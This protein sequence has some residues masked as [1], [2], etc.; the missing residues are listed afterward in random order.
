MD[1]ETSIPQRIDATISAHKVNNITTVQEIIF[2]SRSVNIHQS[3]NT[4]KYAT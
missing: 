3:T 1:R 4:S 2:F